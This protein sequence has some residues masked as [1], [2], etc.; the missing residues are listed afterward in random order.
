N[1]SVCICPGSF[2]STLCDQRPDDGCGATLEATE[3]WQYLNVSISGPENT[4]LKLDPIKCHWWITVTDEKKGIEL[5][6]IAYNTVGRL[7][8]GCIW[9]GVEFKTSQDQAKTGYRLCSMDRAANTTFKAY[10]SLAP[11]M[12]YSYR[13]Q[14][15]ATIR[16][17][18]FDGKI[19]GKI[20]P[21][22]DNDRLAKHTT[23]TL[24][25]KST[26]KP[27]RKPADCFDQMA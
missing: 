19:F 12:V 23:T 15:N 25:P 3:E 13:Y 4:T 7:Y 21:V 11:V 16:Y 17:R 5:Q 26:K 22:N 1:C 2:G 9:G 20:D 14:I 18:S 27:K 6:L 24:K 8:G 10:K